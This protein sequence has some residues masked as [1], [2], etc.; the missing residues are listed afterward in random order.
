M[1]LSHDG[2]N[3]LHSGF[4]SRRYHPRQEAGGGRHPLTLQ[5][6]AAGALLDLVDAGQGYQP[7]GSHCFGFRFRQPM[8][9]SCA[10]LEA[11]AV[12]SK[13]AKASAV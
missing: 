5:L 11:A 13:V 3:R 6:T 9:R 12:S 4:S 10:G 7:V 8:T 2:D 1:S